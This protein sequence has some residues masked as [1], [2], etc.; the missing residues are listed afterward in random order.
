M[1]K[2]SKLIIN[3]NKFLLKLLGNFAFLTPGPSFEKGR[4]NRSLSVIQS[5]NANEVKF[6]TGS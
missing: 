2:R 1:C 3:N 6:L 5:E 4:E